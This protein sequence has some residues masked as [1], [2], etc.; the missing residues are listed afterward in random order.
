MSDWLSDLG[1]SIV[2]GIGDIAAGIG[3]IAK[4]VWENISEGVSDA[5]SGGSIPEFI[6]GLVSPSSDGG[7]SYSDNYAE[8]QG[9]SGAIASGDTKQ[10]KDDGWGDMFN[11]F[12]SNDKNKRTL[13]E[14]G[15]GAVAGMAKNSAAKDAAKYKAEADMS[16]LTKKDQLE[17][18]AN[19]RFSDS[20]GSLAPVKRWT[21]KPLTRMDG[22]RVFTPTGL[23]NTGAK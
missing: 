5:Y 8:R 6:S 22:S 15:F 1:N 2:G 16:L 3:D 13:L 18:D 19:K 12:L 4:D 14:L 7:A 17:Q 23:I 21:P 10:I 9:F 11:T 20:V